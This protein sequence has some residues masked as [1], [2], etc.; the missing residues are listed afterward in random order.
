M[1]HVKTLTQHNPAKAI[2]SD[3]HPNLV[4][5]VLGLLANPVE[6]VQLHLGLL[7]K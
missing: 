2:L 4:D 6:V 1:K 3:D 7:K 5:S